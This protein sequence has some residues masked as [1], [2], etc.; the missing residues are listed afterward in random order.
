MKKIIGVRLG[1]PFKG[2]KPS[3]FILLRKND[4]PGSVKRRIIRFIEKNVDE[5]DILEFQI[6]DETGKKYVASAESLKGEVVN[7]IDDD[8]IAEIGDDDTINISENTDEVNE[9]LPQSHTVDQLKRLRK[10]SKKT[11]IGDRASKMSGG[12]L[13]YERNPIDSGIE[14]YQDFQSHNKKFQP[15][16]NLK[17]L[18]PFRGE[19]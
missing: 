13:S 16:W 6:Q 3:E 1:T 10:I 15:N 12:N 19:K 4:A 11:D 14:S 18:R 9:S 17:N 8:T 7:I 5:F 2:Q